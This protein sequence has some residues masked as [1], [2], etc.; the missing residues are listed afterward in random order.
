MEILRGAVAIIFTFSVAIFVHEL[1]H[2]IFAKIFGIYVETFS[3]GFWKKIWKRK[4]GET[5][6]AISAIPFGGYVKLRGM[7]SKEV[8][9]MLAGDKQE[10]G[11]KQTEDGAAAP[12]VIQESM[13]DSVIEEMNALRQKNYIQKVLVFGAGCINNFLTAVLVFFLLAW[14]GHMVPEPQSSVVEEISGGAAALVPL[15]AGD[16]IL[17]VAGKPVAGIDEFLIRFVG[18]LKDSSATSVPVAVLRD[19]TTMTIFLPARLSPVLAADEKIVQVDG[20]KVSRPED[21]AKYL[22]GMGDEKTTVQATIARGGTEETRVLPAYAAVG[23]YW[24]AAVIGTMDAPYIEMPLPNLPAE[25]AG[26]LS[27]DLMVAVN[28]QPVH[29]RIQATRL[30]RGL[31]GNLVPVTVKRNNKEVSVTV[32][33]RLD[34]EKQ[35]HGQIGIFWGWP[36]TQ[37][38]KLPFGKALKEGFVRSWRYAVVY[39]KELGRLLTSKFQTI[40]ENVGGPIAMGTYAYK[41][42]QKNAVDFFELFALFNIILA[43]TNLFPL[44]VLDGGHILFATIEAITR[45]PIPAKLLIWIYN[46]FIFLIIGLAILITM[47]DV[48]MNMWRLR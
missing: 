43:V 45:R 36:R 18:N 6:Y 14:I 17:A 26:I 3:L 8:E 38:H 28:G 22:L 39:P 42:A 31:A 12:T 5:E 41:A 15:K 30:I 21:V 19:S 11:D 23:I 33:V 47:N 37:Y 34:P 40:R 27:G 1:G 24:P 7:H 4:W 35:S 13:T 25:K 46:F 9:E 44:P 10:K 16:K 20:L 29:S 48:I 32:E 2:F